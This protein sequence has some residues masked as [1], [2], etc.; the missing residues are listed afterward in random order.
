MGG[1]L[2]TVLE[3]EQGKTSSVVGCLKIFKRKT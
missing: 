3:D 1:G 2:V